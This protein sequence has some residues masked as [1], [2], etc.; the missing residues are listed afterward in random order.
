MPS[1]EVICNVKFT[2]K[3]EKNAKVKAK[4]KNYRAAPKFRFLAATFI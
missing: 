1:R 2:L 3:Q 4:G